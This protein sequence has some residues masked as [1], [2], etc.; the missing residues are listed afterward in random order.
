MSSL[1]EVRQAVVV[2]TPHMS[3]IQSAKKK[4]KKSKR[5]HLIQHVQ[6]L[7]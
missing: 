5:L 7:R 3:K 4:K 6:T 1:T 2:F